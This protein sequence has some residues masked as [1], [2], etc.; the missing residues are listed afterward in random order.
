MSVTST[1][2]SSAE[3]GGFALLPAVYRSVTVTSPSRG[4]LASCLL[5]K[6][7]RS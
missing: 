5:W 7:R 2:I 4:T 6:T 1:Q 3:V